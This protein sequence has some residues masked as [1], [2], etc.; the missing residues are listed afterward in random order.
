MLYQPNYCCHCGETVERF[1]WKLWTS[2]RFCVNCEA[3]FRK[4]EWIPRIGAGIAVLFGLFGFGSYLKTPDKP[5][6]LT[7]DQLIVSSSNKAQNNKTEQ[8]AR[9][10]NQSNSLKN[11]SFAVNNN[12]RA[13][14]QISSPT[15]EKKDKPTLTENQQNVVEEPVYFCGAQ[16]KKGTPCTRKVKG[17]GRCWQHLGQTAILPKEKLAA[18]Q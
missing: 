3:A 8:V 9:N 18:S 15:V 7:A 17:G 5:L 13:N 10:T 4:D 6:N 11:Q 14:N 12:S 2:R 1:D 16:T